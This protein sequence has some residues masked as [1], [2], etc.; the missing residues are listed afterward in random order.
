MSKAKRPIGYK[1][2][3]YDPDE[4][5]QRVNFTITQ[6]GEVKSAIAV[7]VAN[8]K[9]IKFLYSEC[10]DKLNE[11]NTASSVAW[12]GL[13]LSR[14]PENVLANQSLESYTTLVRAY[15]SNDVDKTEYNFETL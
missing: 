2:T 15:F 12:D 10:F 1:G 4:T 7:G 14:E 6:T 3:T 13:R 8:T 11:A 9:R 5:F